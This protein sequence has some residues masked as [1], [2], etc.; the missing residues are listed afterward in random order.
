LSE[1]CMK[2]PEGVQ[3]IS[4]LSFCFRALR[5]CELHDNVEGYVS[6]HPMHD[7][8]PSAFVSAVGLCQCW[9]FRTRQE[10][11]RAAQDPYM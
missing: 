10:P 2:G 5:A 7:M 3:I 8:Q 1:T 9:L 4:L 11:Q 6:K